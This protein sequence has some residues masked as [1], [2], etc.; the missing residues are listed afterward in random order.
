MVIRHGALTEDRDQAIVRHPG[1][2][3]DSQV[4][5]QNLDLR[6]RG[7]GDKYLRCAQDWCWV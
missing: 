6:R 4:Y 5:F 2:L 3:R 7:N 1:S